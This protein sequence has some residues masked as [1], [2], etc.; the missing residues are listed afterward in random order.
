MTTTTADRLVVRMEATLRKFER[1]MDQGRRKA[2]RTATGIEN[3]FKTM[4]N[5]VGRSAEQASRGLAGVFQISGRGRF[6]LTNTANQIGDVAVQLQGGTSAARALGQQ[7][8]QLLGGFAALGGAVGVVAPLLGTVAAIG[9]PLAAMLLRNGEASQTLTDR[10]N[11]LSEAVRAYQAAAQDAQTPTEELRDRYGAAS[12]AAREFIMAL[13]DLNEVRAGEQLQS[14]ADSLAGD[15]AQLEDRFG[16]GFDLTFEEAGQ[17]LQ[18]LEGRFEDV[19]RRIQSLDTTVE[20]RTLLRDQ[21]ANERDALLEYGEA[22]DELEIRF[23]IN[24]AA[25]GTLADG[26]VNLANAD[27]PQAVV[28]ATEDLLDRL[29]Q[30]FGSLSQMT[31]KQRAFYEEVVKTGEE[32]ATLVGEIDAGLLSMEG[33]VDAIAAAADG[34]PGLTGLVSDLR[35]ELADAA[36][37]A[38][39]M[40][41]GISASERREQAVGGADRARD[42]VRE[43]FNSQ[44]IRREDIVSVRRT[45]GRSD[46]GTGRSSGGGT[47]SGGGRS[48]QTDAMRE[49]PQR[50]K[51]AERIYLRTRTAAE[52]HRLELERLKELYES[53]AFEDYP[54]AYKRALEELNTELEETEF[55]PLL[56]F[57]DETSTSLAGATESWEAFGDAAVDAIARIA[58]ELLKQQILEALMAIAGPN[59]FL[60]GAINGALGGSASGA[61]ASGFADAAAFGPSRGGTGSLGL[62]SFAGGGGTGNGIRAGGIDGKGGFPALLHPKETVIDHTKGG[63]SL[64]GS[65]AVEI[66]VNDDGTLGAIATQAGGVAAAKIMETHGGKMVN[67]ALATGQ[68]DQGAQARFGIR[69]RA[70]RG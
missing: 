28:E 18:D 22:L 60:G 37:V 9:I 65:V 17:A 47:G 51:D 19:E 20:E 46:S 29:E 58:E 34:V 21:I 3:R 32:A 14:V 70:R 44:G 10:T 67:H 52:Q 24:S 33:L 42:Q 16:E 27:G 6:V 4:G 12:E 54:D 62:P 61:Q 31:A 15:F 23:D 64:E 26:L 36:W 11:A 5:R 49:E 25:A 59:T 55:E 7:M 8:P 43:T 1:Q 30:A 45:G 63:A 40:A 66:F 38:W 57:L 56:S 13:R 69:S 39:R 41:S 68:A 50:L 35:K 48:G 2:N 53:G